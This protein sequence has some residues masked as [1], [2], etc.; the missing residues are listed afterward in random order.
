MAA[1]AAGVND[2]DDVL[3]LS[4]GRA[5]GARGFTPAPVRMSLYW[6]A[7]EGETDIEDEDEDVVDVEDEEDEEEVGR[8]GVRGVGEV[9]GAVFKGMS[10]CGS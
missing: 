8:W 3:C 1:A 5:S 4:V 9:P 7:R 2:L 6:A 10:G